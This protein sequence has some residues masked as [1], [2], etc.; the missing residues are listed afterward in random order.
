MAS[1][2]RTGSDSAGSKGL[3]IASAAFPQAMGDAL[4]KSGID[5]ASVNVPHIAHHIKVDWEDLCQYDTRDARTKA[6]PI[7]CIT[8]L[9]WQ[10]DAEQRYDAYR[11]LVLIEFVTEFGD[12]QY[13]THA[14]SY[15]HTGE[16]LPLSAWLKSV[17]T[18]AMCR[19]G[20]IETSKRE[21][22]VIRPLPVS[23]EVS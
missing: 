11:G 14:M 3:A 10:P 15:A 17:E 13:V 16:F 19:F 9:D 5:V 18:P 21:Q 23:I 8:R 6:S 4:I 7:L 2:T 12:E 22:Y 1:S 20:R